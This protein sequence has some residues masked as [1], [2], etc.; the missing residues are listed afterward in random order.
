[1]A[2]QDKKEKIPTP[3]SNSLDWLN[4]NKDI[5]PQAVLECIYASFET[6]KNLNENGRLPKKNIGTQIELLKK[7][8]IIPSSEKFSPKTKGKNDAEVKKLTFS[9]KEE[10]LKKAIEETKKKIELCTK[11][12][13]SAHTKLAKLKNEQKKLE[14]ELMEIGKQKIEEMILAEEKKL[15]DP[16]Y[17]KKELERIENEEDLSSHEIR[18]P[19]EPQFIPVSENL[20]A[21]PAVF[22]KETTT[23]FKLKDEIK[24]SIPGKIKTFYDERIKFNIEFSVIKEHQLVEKVYSYEHDSL[25]IAEVPNIGPKGF[26]VTYDTISFLVVMASSYYIP[27]NRISKM[28]SSH[29]G[30]AFGTSSICRYLKYFAEC[31]LPIYMQLFEDLSE[32]KVLNCDDTSTKT[33]ETT[34]R[35][36]AQKNGEKNPESQVDKKIFLDPE[37]K[38]SLFDQV[39]SELGFTSQL[40]NGSGPKKKLNVSCLMGKSDEKDFRSYIVFYR[41]HLGSCSNLIEKLLEY[42]SPKNKTIKIQSDLSDTNYPEVELEAEVKTENNGENKI[43]DSSATVE[44]KPKF[45]IEKFG[46]L[47]HARRPFF[48][49]KD[50][51][52][53]L[54]NKILEEF[55]MIA[56]VEGMFKELGRADEHIFYAR[57][58]QER[59]RLKKIFELCEE[60]LKKWPPKSELGKAASYFIENNS[61]IIKYIH[62]SEI[63]STNNVLERAVR[64][65]KL[66]I[67]SAKFRFSENGRVVFDILRT[68]IAT[69]NAAGVPIKEYSSHIMK[70]RDEAKENPQDFTPFAYAKAME[71]AK[72]SS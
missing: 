69:C 6:S 47:A 49:Y 56:V 34:K 20:F 22:A 9:E 60:I 38:I 5:I 30:A 65:E 32:T 63:A 23:F 48:K 42:R 26:R 8:G 27:I 39:E 51:D 35:V 15:E 33:I 59:P 29:G 13:K 54:C 37:A 16:D 25:F 57:F 70:H 53:E 2:G 10:K 45:I 46:C 14:G 71:E 61:T 64:G 31:A 1:M 7:M 3:Y 18:V 4:L 12:T 67:N 68:I 40:K 62:H 17:L 21:E 24:N 58:A 72:N 11:N 55:Q 66:M 36:D 43:S 50:L 19:D 44:K 28:L 52:P 41:A